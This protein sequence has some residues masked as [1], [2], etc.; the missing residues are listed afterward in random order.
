MGK[1]LLRSDGRPAADGTLPNGVCLTDSDAGTE[2]DSATM[3][4][5]AKEWS[6]RGLSTWVAGRHASALD[7]SKRATAIR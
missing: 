6:P 5:R 4:Q 3:K 7:A 2:V 1:A